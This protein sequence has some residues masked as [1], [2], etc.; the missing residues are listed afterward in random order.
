M[1][2]LDI[3]TLLLYRNVTENFISDICGRSK[4]LGMAPNLLELYVLVYVIIEVLGYLMSIANCYFKYAIQIITWKA[5][6]T[7]A[8]DNGELPYLY[9]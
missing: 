6:L 3:F 4:I 5:R 9:G 2:Q 8:D 7:S 1:I